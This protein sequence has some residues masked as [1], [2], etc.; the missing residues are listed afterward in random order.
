[1]ISLWASG[2]LYPAEVM[3]LSWFCCVWHL[4]G[5]RCTPC[6]GGLS[7]CSP[8]AR[9]VL[10]LSGLRHAQDTRATHGQPFHCC[11]TIAL[12]LHA[13]CGVGGW[14]FEFRAYLFCLWS[15]FMQKVLASKFTATIQGL[16]SI[17]AGMLGALLC[18]RCHFKP[19]AQT[20]CQL[21]HSVYDVSE[22]FLFVF[23]SCLWL[24]NLIL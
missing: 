9:S 6:R 21:M 24:I 18:W 16:N 23:A 5:L 17:W 3:K 15:I 8:G 22:S 11:S 19:W 12:W 1:M 10:P 7:L 4:A 2:L 13:A 20:T 14:H